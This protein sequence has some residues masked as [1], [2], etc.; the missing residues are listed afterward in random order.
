MRALFVTQKRTVDGHRIEVVAGV[1]VK[2]IVEER[3]YL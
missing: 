3:M 1:N 2:F